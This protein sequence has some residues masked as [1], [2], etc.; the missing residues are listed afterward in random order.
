MYDELS[1]DYIYYLLYSYLKSN[2]EYT[3]S[4]YNKIKDKDLSIPEGSFNYNLKTGSTAAMKQLIE[5]LRNNIK[6]LKSPN[7]SKQKKQEAEEKFY[8]GH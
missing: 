5:Y 7:I 2:P 1:N 3:K 6:E 4:I 8:Q